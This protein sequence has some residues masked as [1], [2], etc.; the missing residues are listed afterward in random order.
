MTRNGQTYIDIDL[1]AVRVFDRW[2]ITFYPDTLYELRFDYQP[3]FK[4]KPF[5]QQIPVKQLFPTPPRD[6]VST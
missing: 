2:I 4:M 3:R 5:G 1:L 6:A